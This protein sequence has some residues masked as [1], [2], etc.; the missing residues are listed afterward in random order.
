MKKK[1]CVHCASVA[2]VGKELTKRILFQLLL[3]I[4]FSVYFL[5]VV[6]VVLVKSKTV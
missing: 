4:V 3:A 6:Q 5:F 1:Y 2:T